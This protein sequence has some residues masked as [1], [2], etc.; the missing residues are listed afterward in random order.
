MDGRTGRD[1]YQS[2][3]LLAMRSEKQYNGLCRLPITAYGNSLSSDVQYLKVCKIET[4]F[5][6]DDFSFSCL[7]SGHLRTNLNVQLYDFFLT[8]SYTSQASL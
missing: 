3:Q 8:R 6:K 7:N 2:Q 5:K 4:L 1:I